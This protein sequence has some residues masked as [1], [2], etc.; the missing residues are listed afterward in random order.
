M[1]YV[2]CSEHFD[3]RAVSR[4]TS[5]ALVPASSN[6]AD[7]YREL[8]RDIETGDAHS[9]KI[10]AQKA[11]FKSLA[12]RWEQQGEVSLFEKDEILYLVDNAPIHLWRPLLYVIP[13]SLVENRL[14]IVPAAQRAGLGNEYIIPD[15]RRAEFDII[16][17]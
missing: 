3:S 7:I 12:I 11:S 14:Q 5:G 15:L 4:Y 9:A 2:W 6:P 1:H 17:L 13:S 8:R 10:I 16:E